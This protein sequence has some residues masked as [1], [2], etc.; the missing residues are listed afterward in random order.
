MAFG[1][2]PA[3]EEIDGYELHRL[4]CGRK[5]NEMAS[6]FEGLKWA[7]VGWPEIERLHAERAFD[8]AH[9]HFIMPAGILAA[10]LKR[11][12]DVPFLI[13]PH[14]SDVPGYN[15][16]RLKLVHLLVRPWWRRIC[17]SADMIVCP[18][19][20]IRGLLESAVSHVN[21]SVYANAFDAERIRPGNK[22]K[23]ILL[24]SRLV[25]RKGFQYFLQGIR[26]LELPGWQVDLVGEGPM[27]PRIE[28]LARACRVPIT[29]HGWIDNDDPLLARLYARA[30]IFA[31]PSETENFPVSLQEGMSAGCAVIACDIAGSAEVTGDTALLVQP[32]DAIGMRDALLQLAQDPDRCLQMGR[33]ARERVLDAFEPAAIARR[34]I[35]ALNSGERMGVA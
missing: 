21:T 32:R 2:L 27:Y 23:H 12:H 22:S 20:S 10:A 13:T 30:M 25:E 33:R 18:S 6:P 28:A 14:G 16:E 8:M 17:R 26:D 5:K 34:H 4:P 19:Q 3:H 35:E 15:Q 11:A 24:C 9:A 1:D 29:M 7:R 31:L